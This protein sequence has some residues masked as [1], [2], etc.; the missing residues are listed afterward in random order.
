MLAWCLLDEAHYGQFARSGIMNTRISFTRI[1]TAAAIVGCAFVGMHAPRAAAQDAAMSI[2]GAAPLQ[3]TLLPT[4][5]VTASRRNPAAEPSLSIADAAPLHVT[6]LPTV[7][8]TARVVADLTTLLPVVRVVAEA[9][10]PW[11]AETQGSGG[12]TMALPDVDSD[13][14]MAVRSRMMP[15]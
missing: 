14:G 15:R 2:D 4:V 9:S 12:T 7:R 5:S 13:D 11:R 3:A 6:L 8:V 1:A 10:S